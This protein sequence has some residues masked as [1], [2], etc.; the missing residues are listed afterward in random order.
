[1]NRN[2]L[3]QL[4]I[5]KALDLSPASIVKYKRKG[6]PMDSIDAAAAWHRSRVKVTA[7]RMPHAPAPQRPADS[8][9]TRAA[10]LLDLAAN[11][12]ASGH[13]ISALV[14]GLRSALHAVPA[15]DRAAM[16]L[17]VD[18]MDV[19]TADVRKVLQDDEPGD[20]DAQGEMSGQAAVWLG[21]FWF[22]VAA[23]E[24]RLA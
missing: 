12:H 16:L 17:P 18:V 5:A 20:D 11:A 3:T 10:D 2:R 4:E 23:G 9:A 22:S 15:G 13:D 1:M 19:L 24:I 14:P 6:M 7:H 8:A 21:V